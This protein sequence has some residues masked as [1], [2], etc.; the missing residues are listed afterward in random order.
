[1]Q[2]RFFNLFLHCFFAVRVEDLGDMKSTIS[3]GVPECASCHI[4]GAQPSG[5]N[6]DLY[7]LHK[8]SSGFFTD[9]PKIFLLYKNQT[10]SYKYVTSVKS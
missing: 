5:E 3:A 2:K 8:N 6:S 4:S 10:Y 7:I 1:M 9:K